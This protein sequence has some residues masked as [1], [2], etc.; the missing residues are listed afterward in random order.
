MP[1]DRL[2]A[3][4]ALL[5]G[6]EF[7]PAPCAWP[8]IELAAGLA[9]PDE[10]KAY[11]DT[12]PP[13][14]MRGSLLVYH[15]RL[16]GGTGTFVEKWLIANAEFLKSHAKSL[17]TRSGPPL[18]FPYDFY[19]ASGGLLP[20]AD[21]DGYAFL[22]WLTSHQDPNMWPVVLCNVDLGYEVVGGSTLTALTR[23]IRLEVGE[24]VAPDI[25]TE[26][27]AFEKLSS[28]EIESD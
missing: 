25:R 2:F 27:I 18:E 20:W 17:T 13:G 1:S 5:T 24:S 7:E 3:E 19:P 26:P 12:F 22:C 11:I 23:V 21:S 15:P 28:L 9:F 4:L 14:V 10:Y 16:K 6:A 8:E